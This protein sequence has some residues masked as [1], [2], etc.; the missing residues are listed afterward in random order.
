VR[1][2]FSAQSFEWPA[3]SDATALGLTA[4]RLLNKLR[5]IRL[6]IPAT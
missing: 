2:D 4:W 3:W 6:I 5:K 1:S